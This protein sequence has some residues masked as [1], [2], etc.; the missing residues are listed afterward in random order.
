MPRLPRLR[1]ALL[2]LAVFATPLSAAVSPGFTDVTTL[3]YPGARHEIFN[4]VMQT[5]VRAD[6]LAWLDRHFPVRD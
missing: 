6:L 5:D 1:A 4:E 3:V 2:A